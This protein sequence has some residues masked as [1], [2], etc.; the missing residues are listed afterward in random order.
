MPTPK[1]EPLD[2]AELDNL[3][4]SE[5]WVNDAK[6]SEDTADAR[7]QRYSQI[8]QAHQTATP[9]R[10]W[11]PAKS[12]SSSTGPDMWVK[13]TA[14]ALIAIAVLGALSLLRALG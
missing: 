11:T 5:D 13:V 7:V 14:I 2:D 10:S 3:T 9:P 8:H 4:L 6:A 1:P 12:A